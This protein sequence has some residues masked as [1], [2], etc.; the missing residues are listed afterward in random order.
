MADLSASSSLSPGGGVLGREVRH[1]GV[2]L[3]HR[4]FEAQKFHQHLFVVIKLG[5]TRGL[6]TQGATKH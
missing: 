3:G 2:K 5:Q 6:S 4:V 1:A